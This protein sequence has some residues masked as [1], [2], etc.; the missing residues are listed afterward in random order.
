MFYLY[1]CLHTICSFGTH[2]EQNNA[3]D[4][5]DLKLWML[6][7][8]KMVLGTE[9]D[10]SGKVASVVNCCAI[11]LTHR[12]LFYPFVNILLEFFQEWW[13]KESSLRIWKYVTNIVF[14]MIL[15]KSYVRKRSSSLDFDHV[16]LICANGSKH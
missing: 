10:Y 15:R 11:S 7:A 5:L 6:L 14:S 1:V 16:V 9:P 3:L 13:C 8:T 2:G 4:P 12:Y